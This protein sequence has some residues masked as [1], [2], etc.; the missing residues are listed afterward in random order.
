MR[1][2]FGEMSLDTDIYQ[3]RQGER[4]LHLSPK[5]LDLLALLVTE[6]RRVVSKAELFERLWPSTFV[7]EGNLPVLIREIRAALN[8]DKHDIIR[9]VHGTGYGFSASVVEFAATRREKDP[10][11]SLAVLPLVNS[12]AQAEHEYLA[13]GITDSVINTLALLPRLRLMSRN[14]S[15]RFKGKNADARQIGLQLGV[16]AVVMGTLRQAGDQLVVNL[17]LVNTADGS[18]ILSRQYSRKSAD[19]I[20]LPLT[21]AHDVAHYLRLELSD[22]DTAKLLKQPSTNPEAYRL[23]LRG[24]HHL[25]RLAPESLHEAIRYLEQAVAQDSNF[26]AAFADMAKAYLQLGIYFESARDMM[27]KAKKYAL[28]ALDIDTTL[29]DAHVSLGVINFIYDWD[30]SAAERE[31]VLS[32][33]LNPRAVETFSCSSH[34]LESAGRIDDAERAVRRGLVV[35]PLSTPLTTE[36][37]CNSYYQRRYDRAIAEFGKAL[38]LD[39]RNP[40]AHWGLGRAYG[41]KKMYTEALTALHRVAQLNGF[42]PPLVLAEIGYVLASSGHG[43]EA[44]EVIAKLEE[45]STTLYVDPYLVAIIYLALDQ[46]DDA[47]RCLSN[48]YEEKS[49]FVVSIKGE[50]KWDAVRDD[51]RFVEILSGIGF[52]RE[53]APIQAAS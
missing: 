7:V 26:A 29:A 15:F 4:V 51:P 40:V 31:L 47:L 49:G 41:Q 18:L 48:A 16:G 42:A 35:D 2:E 45:L 20:A 23:Y 14:A 32:S 17:E 22:E 9:T 6:R 11:D 1:Y 8:D 10:I 43:N 36:L 24:R 34:L 39:A 5:A 25:T 53:T 28:R 21:I 38:D 12:G 50:P 52:P 13:D 19:V 27:P 30:W 3:L 44:R 37:G 46:T 33:E